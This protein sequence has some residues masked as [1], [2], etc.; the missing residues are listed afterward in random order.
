MLPGPSGDV[1]SDDGVPEKGSVE[2]ASITKAVLPANPPPPKAK[3]LTKYQQK[4]DDGFK[5]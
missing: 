2:L 3:K 5:A 1:V 4:M